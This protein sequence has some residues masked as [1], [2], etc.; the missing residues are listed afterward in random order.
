MHHSE[1]SKNF[2]DSFLKPYRPLILVL[3][4]ILAVIA[5]LQWRQDGFNLQ[6]SMRLFMGLFFLCFGSFKLLDWKGF[7]HA[8]QGYDIIAKRSRLYAYLYPLVELCLAGLYLANWYPYWTNVATVV[9]MG[10]SSI[11]VIEAVTNKRKIQCACL[12]TVVNLPMTTVTI[13]EDVGMGLMA[14]LMLWWM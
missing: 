7:V 9:V 14:L 13:I 10:V 11:G 4:A 2:Q 5:V 1:P 12:G 6:E 3:T 8:Y